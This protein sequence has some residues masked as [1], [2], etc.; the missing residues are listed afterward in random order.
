MRNIPLSPSECQVLPFSGMNSPNTALAHCPCACL[1]VLFPSLPPD[2]Q[3]RRSMRPREVFSRAGPLNRLPETGAAP[4]PARL[5]GVQ[6]VGCRS[7]HK[8]RGPILLASTIQLSSRRPRVRRRSGPAPS[9]WIY[10]C[11]WREAGW[12]VP[13]GSQAARAVGQAGRAAA[14]AWGLE[15][16]AAALRELRSA[17]AQHRSRVSRT[18]WPSPSHLGR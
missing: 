9:G 13:R 7:P 16:A 3:S 2:S 1:A 15:A 8:E 12:R 6:A 17:Q 10:H 4:L 18:S 5:S 14:G 11:S